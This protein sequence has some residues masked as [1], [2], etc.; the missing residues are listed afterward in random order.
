MTERVDAIA[1]DFSDRSGAAKLQVSAYE[2]NAHRIAG[3]E[4]PI[5]RHLTGMETRGAA[6]GRDES[7]GG[8]GGCQKIG[9]LRIETGDREGC[10]DRSQQ[11]A[12]LTGRERGY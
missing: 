7:I 9:R 10:R 6:A 1:V 3:L 11:R 4:R 12:E 8:K 5:E 2:L